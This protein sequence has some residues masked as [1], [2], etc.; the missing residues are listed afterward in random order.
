MPKEQ[1]MKDARDAERRKDYFWAATYYDRA[2]ETEKAIE[3]WE[4]AAQECEKEGSYEFAHSYYIKAANFVKADEAIKKHEEKKEKAINQV[5]EIMGDIGQQ[6]SSEKIEAEFKE[7]SGFQLK[8]EAEDF[9]KKELYNNAAQTYKASAILFD[10]SGSP[11]ETSKS[12]RKY[13]EMQLKLG[14]TAE[15]L[16]GLEKAGDGKILLAIKK[17]LLRNTEESKKER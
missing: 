2:G 8:E 7:R 12:W 10:A 11:G 17:W 4:K 6:K 9:E 15:V 14:D 3:F 16:S 5:R 13:A 1:A